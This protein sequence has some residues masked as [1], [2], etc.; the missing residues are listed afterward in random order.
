MKRGRVRLPGGYTG[1]TF[2][3]RK[4]AAGCDHLVIGCRAEREETDVMGREPSPPHEYG[5]ICFRDRRTRPSIPGRGFERIAV[6]VLVSALCMLAIASGTGLGP[7]GASAPTAPPKT[8][9]TAEIRFASR[10]VRE[11]RNLRGTLFLRNP[12]KHTIDLNDG[13]RPQWEVALGTGTTPPGVAFT[14]LCGTAPFPVR[15]G[16]RKLPFTVSTSGL[17]PGR[18]RAFL[19][20]STETFPSA[21]PVPVRVSR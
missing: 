20:A 5:Q 14:D 16:T 15:P 17:D 10:T 1:G 18:Y 7:A 4:L 12:T 2:P 11:G 21:K 6:K 13:C 19:I 8:R 3:T 9:I